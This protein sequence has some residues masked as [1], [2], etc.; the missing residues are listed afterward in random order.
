MP[1]LHQVADL[2]A[3][4]ETQ[5]KVTINLNQ[6]GNTTIP[7]PTQD[8]QAFRYSRQVI[9]EGAFTNECPDFVTKS[10]NSQ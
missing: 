1:G 3:Y 7:F 4:P 2:T 9:L 8:I 10:S 6:K 5:A